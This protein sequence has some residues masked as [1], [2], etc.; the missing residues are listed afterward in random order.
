MLVTLSFAQQWE[1][2]FSYAKIF[3]KQRMPL[4][5]VVTQDPALPYLETST[6]PPLSASEMLLDFLISP[7]MSSG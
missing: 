5:F 2:L 7:H 4:L 1:Y 6:M 3:L